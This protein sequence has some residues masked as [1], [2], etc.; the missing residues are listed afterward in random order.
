[1]N[2]NGESDFK[3]TNYLR[4]DNTTPNK[5]PNINQTDK[6]IKN[7]TSEYE[8]NFDEEDNM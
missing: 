2:K 4:V 5:E 8:D 1:M 7:N 6:D 3:D